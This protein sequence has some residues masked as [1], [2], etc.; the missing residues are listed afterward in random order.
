[1]Q[2]FEQF[3]LADLVRIVTEG[4]RLGESAATA[5]RIG[6][7]GFL[8]LRHTLDLGDALRKVE[9]SCFREIP[10]RALV[11]ARVRGADRHQLERS[12]VVEERQERFDVK[13]AAQHHLL[14]DRD[15][16]LVDAVETGRPKNC[17]PLLLVVL[18][19]PKR[20]IL[21]KSLSKRQ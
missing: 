17:Q 16:Q 6:I 1:M 4:V 20:S 10:A 12:G 9:P 5:H 21:D 2:K 3:L 7:V 8:V 18:A 11:E 19:P 13:V 14:R 15:R